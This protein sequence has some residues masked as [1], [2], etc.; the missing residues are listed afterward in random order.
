MSDTISAL[1]LAASGMKAQS[2]RLRHL[3]ENIANVDTPGYRRKLVSLRNRS[4]WAAP[5]AR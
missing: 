4:V 1:Q 5:R 2:D 3:S